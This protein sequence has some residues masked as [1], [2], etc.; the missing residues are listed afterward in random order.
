MKVGLI[1]LR[2]CGKTTIFNVLTGQRAATGSYGGS[3]KGEIHLGVIKVPDLRLDRLAEILHP[4][5]TTHAEI[6][7]TDFPGDSASERRS[8]Q[9]DLSAQ[10]REVDAMAL[11]L[12]DF[13]PE[14]KPVKEF[15]DLLAE[16]ILAD[17][18]VVEK[19]LARLKKEKGRE[20][21]LPLLERC[22]QN[23]E[24]EV[25]LRDLS[26]TPEEENLLSGFGLL[27]RKPVLALFNTAEERAGRPLPP[28]YE[29]ELRRRRI[30]GLAMAGKVEME[31]DQLDEVDRAPFLKEIGIP[32]PARDRFIRAC[33]QLMDLVSF[34][35]TV[36]D[37]LRAWTIKRGTAAKKAAG[38][39]HTDMERGF[40][41]AE[42]VAYEDFVALGSDARCREAGKLR[43]EGKD[44]LVRDGDIVRFRFNV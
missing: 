15:D 10:M 16:M 8:V 25:G 28:A 22:L 38:K 6:V 36:S 37:E 42:V 40:I 1:G 43:L 29:E 33:F 7:F 3:T 39:I 13:I 30:Q 34:F 21:E 32:E 19:R 11:V 9:S 5:K 2:G 24:N 35:T 23:L 14:A 26:F 4:R 12:C 27:S 31:V 44:Y 18:A 20:K 17:L 41:R